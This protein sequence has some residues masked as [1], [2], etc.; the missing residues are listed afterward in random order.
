MIAGTSALTS[1][2]DLTTVMVV[3]LVVVVVVVVKG[4]AEATARRARRATLLKVDILKMER[5]LMG[6]YLLAKL[7]KWKMKQ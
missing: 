7:R 4:A 6:R 5:G 3:E 2:P 1:G